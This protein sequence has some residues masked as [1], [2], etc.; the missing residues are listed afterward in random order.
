MKDR[1]A[2]VTLIGCFL[3]ITGSISLVSISAMIG[4]QEAYELMSLSIMSIPIQYVISY[5]GILVT[6]LS[7]VAVLRGCN[8][9]RYLYVGWTAIAFLVGL[10]TNPMKLMMIPGFITFIIIAVFLF[11]PDAQRFFRS[12]DNAIKA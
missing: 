4:N 10:F 11:R 7:G 8:W 9:A 3:I 6:I 5:I 2:S 12:P 1:P